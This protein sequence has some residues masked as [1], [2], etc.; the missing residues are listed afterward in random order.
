MIILKYFVT[1]HSIDNLINQWILLKFANLFTSRGYSIF[2]VRF[3]FKFK[4]TT[5][6]FDDLSCNKYPN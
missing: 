3:E 4:I 1:T 2:L 5:N 6:Q